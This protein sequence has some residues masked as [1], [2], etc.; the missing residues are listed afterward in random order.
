MRVSMFLCTSR[1]NL[2]KNSKSTK[3]TPR[4]RYNT[5]EIKQIRR[6]VEVSNIERC[7][8][9]GYVY[10]EKKMAKKP[11]RQVTE[12]IYPQITINVAYLGFLSLHRGVRP[13][14]E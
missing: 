8:R 7:G 9:T 3:G 5:A 2:E 1:S 10:I 4:H 12:V 6:V 13:R 14:S 11:A